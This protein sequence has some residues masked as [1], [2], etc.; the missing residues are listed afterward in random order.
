MFEVFSA[1]RSTLDKVNKL[2]PAFKIPERVIAPVPPMLLAAPSVTAPA[3]EAAVAL[4]FIKA[5]ELLIP[6]PLI[7]N[8]LVLEIVCP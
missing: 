6:V 3:Y 5:P 7:V 4:L 8:A 2:L 1:V